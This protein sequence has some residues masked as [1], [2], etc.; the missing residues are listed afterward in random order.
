MV[1]LCAKTPRDMAFGQASMAKDKGEE[2][3][4][5]RLI[6]RVDKDKYLFAIADGLGS[7]DKANEQSVKAVNMI[8]SFY[9][10]GFN[11]D[12]VIGLT[13]KLLTFTGGERYNTLDMCIVD[14]SAGY[15]D[16][17][18]MGACPAFIKRGE[19]VTVIEGESLPMGAFD[20]IKPSIIKSKIKENDMIVLASD[21]ITD[22]VGVDELVFL[23]QKVR[24][25]NPQELASIIKKRATERGALDDIS[26]IVGKVYPTK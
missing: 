23:L 15:C 7:G 12:T 17:I 11:R 16:F 9:K 10:A 13:N 19:N 5:S 1:Y 3:G 20:E 26:V 4:D 21:G 6:L 8:E 18:K 25:P 22:S 14:L 24:T 2:N